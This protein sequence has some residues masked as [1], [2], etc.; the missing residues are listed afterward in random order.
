MTIELTFHVYFKCHCHLFLSCGAW[1]PCRSISGTH[2][3]AAIQQP[4]LLSLTA[5]CSSISM[6]LSLRSAK[7]RRA[8]AIERSMRSLHI[9]DNLL[10]A[11]RG[12]RK[13]RTKTPRRQPATYHCRLN[14]LK[15]RGAITKCERFYAPLSP[16]LK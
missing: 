9:G 1:P 5:G 13:N 8:F 15:R 6:S 2:T 12:C 10:A 7:S 16:P 14:R 11:N 4:L 3:H